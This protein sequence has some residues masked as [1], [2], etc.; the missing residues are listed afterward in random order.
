MFQK[1]N[2]EKTKSSQSGSGTGRGEKAGSGGIRKQRP[3]KVSL[4]FGT[5]VGSGLGAGRAVIMRE[6]G[7][8]PEGTD[9]WLSGQQWPPAN[10]PWSPPLPRP[11]SHG[12]VTQPNPY[13]FAPVGS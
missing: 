2:E 10:G 7:G 4:T 12:A 6:A 13:E 3:T 11:A 9:Q 8:L 1:D 5:R